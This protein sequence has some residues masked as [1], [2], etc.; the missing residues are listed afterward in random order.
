MPLQNRVNPTGEI[1]TT[2]ARGSLMGNRGFI[3]DPGSR[4]LLKRRW[5]HQAWVCCRLEFGGRQRTVMGPRTY[6]ELFFLDEA[7]ALAAGHRPCETCRRREYVAFRAAWLKG[8]PNGHDGSLPIQLIDRQ[9]HS[10]RVK[11]RRRQVRFCAPL[12]RL[13]PGVMIL[14][15]SWPHLVCDDHLLAWGEDGYRTRLERCSRT[16]KV[17]TPRSTAATLRAGY[18]PEVHSSAGLTVRGLPR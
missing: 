10:E 7:T 4:T 18:R 9:M 15:D 12:E 13:P 11:R 6:T 3:H 1:V 5:T 8:N 14:V 16:V 17:L 2:D